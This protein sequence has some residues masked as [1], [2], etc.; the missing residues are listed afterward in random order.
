MNGKHNGTLTARSGTISTTPTEEIHLKTPG[1]QNQKQSSATYTIDIG[2]NEQNY[3]QPSATNTII[4]G[5]KTKMADK[6]KSQDDSS[7]KRKV[8]D[9]DLEA[10]NMA[11][12]V[13]YNSKDKKSAR[14]H[15]NKMNETAFMTEGAASR[16]DVSSS[17]N[18]RHDAPSHNIP[19]HLLQSPFN[20]PSSFKCPSSSPAL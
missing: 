6:E 11:T 12:I 9:T 4:I 10:E 13:N 14:D 2:K 7:T 16:M 19:P 20:A 15:A 17:N 5:T 8:G 1:N 18:I 3:K